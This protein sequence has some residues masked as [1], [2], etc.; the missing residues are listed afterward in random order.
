MD[1][2]IELDLSVTRQL[3]YWSVRTGGRYEEGRRVVGGRGT[4]TRLRIIVDDMDT[5]H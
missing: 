3:L 1:S 4:G 2:H 5:A